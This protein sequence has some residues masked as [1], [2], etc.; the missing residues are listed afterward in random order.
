[1][2]TDDEV[3]LVPTWAIY[4]KDELKQIESDRKDAERWR[5]LIRL[6]GNVQDGSDT[7]VKLFWDIDITP[8]PFIIIRKKT[9][10]NAGIDN[11]E[12]LIDSIPE[13]HA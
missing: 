7:T 1:M 2:T 8:V 11:F 9:H 5:K 10:W 6:V 12:D 4:L 13:P 3:K